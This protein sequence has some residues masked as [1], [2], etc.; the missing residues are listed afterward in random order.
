MSRRPAL[1]LALLLVAAA[2]AGAGVQ[3]ASATCTPA[4]AFRGWVERLRATEAFSS[5]AGDRPA[6]IDRAGT[7]VL[8][9]GRLLTPAGTVTTVGPHPYG[10]AVSLD[11]RTVATSNSGSAP[12]SVSLVTGADGPAPVVRTVL[13]R[14]TGGEVPTV[15]MGLAFSPDGLTL[16]A[17]GGGSGKLQVIDVASGQVT[18]T[19]D[20]N[21]DLDGRTYQSSFLGDLALS[22]DGSRLYV[23]DQ[24]NFRLVEVAVA[25][26]GLQPLRSLPTG[27]YPFSV[28]L[29]PDGQHAFVA[30]V[31]TYEYSPVVGFDPADPATALSF[32][33]FGAP[34]KA[35]L[36]GAV[37][38]G[39]HV[40]ALGDPNSRAAAAVW[41]LDLRAGT[42]RARI[43]TGPLVGQVVDGLP[44]TGTSAPAAVLDD[45][46]QVWV[47]NNHSD[48][49]AVLDPTTG[50]LSGTVALT[51]LAAAGDLRGVQPFGLALSPDRATLFV[52][53]SGLNA[54]AVIDTATRTVLGHLPAGWLPSKL[55]VSPD[56]STLYV[57]NAR[58]F[59]N[60]PNA[61]LGNDPTSTGLGRVGA[62]VTNGT[63]QAVPIADLRAQ[64][65]RNRLASWTDQ[66]RTNA[67]LVQ[68]RPG[69]AHRG[70]VGERPA[71]PIQ[72]VVVVVKE[73]RT[74][75]QVLGDV[76][77]VGNRTAVGSPQVAN[78]PVQGYGEHATVAGSVDPTRPQVIPDVDIT[79]NHH[80]LARRYAFS[81][82]FYSDA[83]VSADGHRW[84]VGV[85]PDAFVETSYPQSYGGGLSY[86]PQTGPNPA[87]GRRGVTAAQAALA[88]EEYPEAGSIWENAQRGGLS[89][90]DFGE[91]LELADSDE[92]SQQYPTGAL[93]GLNTPLPAALFEHTARDFPEFNTTISDQYRLDV[94]QRHLRRNDVG[95]SR[96]LP[97]LSYVWLE[98]DHGGTPDASLGYPYPQSFPAD[99]DLAL[100]RLVSTLSTRPD[101]SSTAV[102]VLEDD[103]QGGLDTVDAHRTLGMIMS[104]WAKRSFVSAEHTSTASVVKTIELLLG[105]P[106]LNQA[107]ATANDLLDMFTD[108]ADASAY[109]LQLSDQRVFDETAV[110]RLSE[111]EGATPGTSSRSAQIDD[112]TDR[113]AGQPG[114]PAVLVAGKPVDVRPQPVTA[115]PRAA[116]TVA[117]TPVEQVCTT[118]PTGTRPSSPSSGSS[119]SSGSAAPVTST[120]ATT[121]VERASRPGAALPA[122]GSNPL[123]RTVA[124]LLLTIAAVGSRMQFRRSR[125]RP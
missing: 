45:G 70:L 98:Q 89:Y 78:A 72:H 101:W 79:P 5:P 85:Q 73:N 112:P 20:L 77:K 122:T 51:P 43:K 123:L 58:G 74:Y 87:P 44:A 105:L 88:P 92:R 28:T 23:V 69:T 121:S 14:A 82:N 125:D 111:P 57:A 11:G 86:S 1:A 65:G 106:M 115:A 118:G 49:V 48:S 8:P 17:S 27:R 18:T 117:A 9:S 119:S 103:P 100:G 95:V 42:V 2:L 47:S 12:F 25:I 99:N 107:D 83:D 3:A 37:V 114:G 59:G 75:D 34:T 110:R 120:G 116:L 32:P 39:K 124:V 90:Y 41:D 56:G 21:T 26:T 61:S 15:F 16:Y 97:Q 67:G 30:A 94:V 102:I 38:E 22:P 24:A 55:S 4:P 66:V 19:V 33:P 113:P 6:A 84:L 63:L 40:P 91:G 68:R 46:R 64:A 7:T 104:P 71:V 81:D 93:Y 50:R 36:A 62:T 109:P 52:A 29:S 108:T 54:V 60:G 31:G 96:G 80:A 35:S 13:P 76:G 53:E 10:L